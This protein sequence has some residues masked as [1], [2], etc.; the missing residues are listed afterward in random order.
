MQRSSETTEG[1]PFMEAL[2]INFSFIDNF[3][4]S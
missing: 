4:Q 3:Q 1:G 2:R